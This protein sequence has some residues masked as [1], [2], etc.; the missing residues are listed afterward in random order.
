MPISAT[1][2]HAPAS[3]CGPH[4]RT[5]AAEKNQP[6]ACSGLVV[7]FSRYERGAYQSADTRRRLCFVV[8]PVLFVFLIVVVVVPVVV[9]VIFFIEVF[10]LIVDLFPLFIVE[11]V[12]LVLI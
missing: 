7:G 2:P 4:Q 3:K 12:V 5:D 9:L 10:V 1:S 6:P 8:F 11:V